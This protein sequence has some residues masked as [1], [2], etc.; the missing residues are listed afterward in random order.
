MK[1]K[2]NVDEDI[3]IDLVVRCKLQDDDCLRPH[4]SEK[5]YRVGKLRSQFEQLHAKRR[6]KQAEVATAT[7]DEVDA[8]E[9]LRVNAAGTAAAVADASPGFADDEPSTKLATQDELDHEEVEV[10]APP[11]KPKPR[12]VRRAPT[13]AP[14]S[15]D[16]DDEAPFAK[17]D[18]EVDEYDLTPMVDMAFLLN[19]FFMLTTAYALLHSMRIPAPKPDEVSKESKA[20]QP[21]SKDELDA[22]IVVQI[23]ADNKLRVDEQLTDPDSL[24]RA[25]QGRMTDKA[26]VLIKAHPDAY[27]ESLV[28]VFDSCNELRIQNI[29]L[30]KIAAFD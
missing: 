6:Q 15:S 11:P 18:L 19:M 21:I 27:H 9:A 12:P 17:R 4:G 25:I 7:T 29:N 13:K 14:K 26:S 23:D 20:S 3:V 1:Q 2:T 8:D 5:W 22:M 24:T 10:P 28:R 30:A 16:L